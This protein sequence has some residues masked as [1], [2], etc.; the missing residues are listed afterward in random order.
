MSAHAHPSSR[1][2]RHSSYSLLL[3]IMVLAV[4]EI[5]VELDR[6]VRRDHG[7]AHTTIQFECAGCAPNQPRGVRPLPSSR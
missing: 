2:G 5:R 4:Q 3:A 6:L 7:V 1:D